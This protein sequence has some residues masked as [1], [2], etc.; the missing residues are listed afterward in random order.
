MPYTRFVQ[1]GRLALVNFGEEKGK[2]GVI[3][4]VV[5]SNRVVLAGPTTGLR[6]QVVPITHIVLTKFVLK[7]PRNPSPKALRALI[8]K[9][10]LV[11]KFFASRWGQKLRQ[12]ETRKGLTDF[13]RFQ[14]AHL[15]ATRARKRSA[16]RK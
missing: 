13:Q 14:V 2:L 6:R 4:D 16:Q 1:I 5:D 8:E 15:R 12:R 7:T 9:D 11:E 3:V 10:E